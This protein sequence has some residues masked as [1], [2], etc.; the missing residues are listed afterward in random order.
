MAPVVAP[1]TA[2]TSRPSRGLGRRYD[3]AMR[4][5]GCLVLLVACRPAL[6]FTPEALVAKT[7][8]TTEMGS[9]MLGE[10]YE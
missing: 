4:F 9:H 6:T 3:R 7:G 10:D 2:A 5:H 8:D 1:M